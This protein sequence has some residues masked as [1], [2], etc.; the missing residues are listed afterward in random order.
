M[1]DSALAPWRDAA[2]ILLCLEAFIVGLLPL[3]VIYLANR[4]VR[5]LVVRARPF[6]RAVRARTDAVLAFTNRAMDRLA[7]PF[8][9]W[10]SWLAGAQ[11]TARAIARWLAPPAAFGKSRR[12]PLRMRPFLSL[13][14]KRKRRREN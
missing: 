14:D 8:I 11:A 12:R 13:S 5:R 3:A 9:A 6:F 7:S 10:H 2:L 4:G 1:N